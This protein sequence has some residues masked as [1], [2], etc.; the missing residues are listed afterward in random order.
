MTLRLGALFGRLQAAALHPVL[1]PVREQL[2]LGASQIKRAAGG[3]VAWNYDPIDVTEYT[4]AEFRAAVTATPT[5][6]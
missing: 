6:G 2:M 3:G 5:L 4:L 1:K